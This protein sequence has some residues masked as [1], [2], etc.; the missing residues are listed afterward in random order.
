MRSI[1]LLAVAFGLEA[2]A[3]EKK[4]SR[5]E[6]PRPVLEAVLARYP[7]GKLVRFIEE[8]EKG[9]KSYEVVIEAGAKRV[10][11]VLSAD[12]KPLLEEQKISVA[13][14]PAGV[15]TALAAS[16]YGKARVLQ[17]E[18]LEDLKTPG[19]A[20]FEVLVEQG[21]KKRELVF[22]AAGA[23]TKDEDVTHED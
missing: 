15:R 16:A 12:G 2:L 1:V 21:G 10:E 20:T 6:V 7:K 8:S 22:D 3:G 9:Q 19:A 13:E 4:I 5:E 17:V 11:L 18:R 14:L 23:L